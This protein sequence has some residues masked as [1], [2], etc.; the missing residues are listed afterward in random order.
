MQND[1]WDDL[2]FLLAIGRSRS[3]LEASRK[4]G[5]NQTTVTRRLEQYENRF[6]SL[7]FERSRGGVRPTDAGAKMIVHAERVELEV[8][9][10]QAKL[11]GLDQ[12]AEGTVRLTAVPAVVNHLLVPALPDL[13]TDHPNLQLELVA[14]PKS[15]SLTQREADFA[16]RLNRPSE[17]TQI[18]VQK[19]GAFTY[20]AYGPPENGGG[21]V[22]WIVYDETMAHLP[23]AK[24]LTA[25]SAGAP[26]PVTVN[27]AETIVACIRAGLGK[28]VLPTALAQH[29]SGIQRI[30][31]QTLPPVRDVWL[32]SHPHQK[33]LVRMQVVARWVKTVLAAATGAQTPKR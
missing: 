24:W 14:E 32:L 11:S 18:L 16:I 23:H 7:L 26:A 22:P 6:G 10:A 15:L 13:L 21:P 3:L 12:R 29:I 30:K 33:N 1:N 25:Q 31:T 5:V 8:L 4:L 9:A 27:D 19:I 2:R 20:A 17:E 28:S